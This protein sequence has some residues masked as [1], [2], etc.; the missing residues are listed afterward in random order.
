MKE[1]SGSLYLLDSPVKK[2]R[3]ISLTIHIIDGDTNL[4]K[5]KLAT[6]AV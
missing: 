4:S 1:I 6:I 2:P 5:E 3:G